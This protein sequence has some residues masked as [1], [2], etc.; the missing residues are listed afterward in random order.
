MISYRAQYFPDISLLERKFERKQQSTEQRS[1]TSQPLKKHKSL[2]A[3]N[4]NNLFHLPNPKEMLSRWRQ[5]TSNLFIKQFYIFQ[6]FQ[7]S[8]IS[9]VSRK[10]CKIGVGL[11]G[12]VT[13][14][15][16]GPIKICIFQ[17]SGVTV[18]VENHCSMCWY[19][20]YHC[21]LLG[22]MPRSCLAAK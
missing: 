15:Q 20:S 8:L 1:I 19:Y 7:S 17:T 3:N 16:L 18:E 21:C 13:L 14:V 2:K 9:E 22:S 5:V 11:G 10:C 12:W 6:S 4:S